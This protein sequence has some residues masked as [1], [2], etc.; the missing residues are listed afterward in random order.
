MRAILLLVLAIAVAAAGGAAYLVNDY[1]QAQRQLAEDAGPALP[2]FTGQRVLVADETIP[3]GTALRSSM[4]RWQPWPPEDIMPAYK[5][6]GDAEGMT[7]R[8]V[9]RQRS[10]HEEVMQGRIV[11]RT[12]AAGEPITDRMVFERVNANFLAGALNPG[13][14]AIALPVN[15]VTGTA[16]FILPGDYVDV[17]LTH[18]LRDT[19][20]RGVDQGGAG[21]PISRY[22]A[23]TIIESLR[24]LAVDRV[25]QDTEAEPKVVQTVTVEASASEVEIL[26]LARQM[27]S[28][29]LTLR[30]LSDRQAPVGLA[31]LLGFGEAAGAPERDIVSDR[32]VS[33]ALDYMM[34][35]SQEE[36]RLRREAELAA[37]RARLL[38]ELDLD[39]EPMP[40]RPASPSTPAQAAPEPQG[41]DWEVTVYHGADGPTVYSDQG[42]GQAWDGDDQSGGDSGPGTGL[43]D[44]GPDGDPLPLTPDMER[45]IPIEE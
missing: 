45:E 24:V 40:P 26:N 7:E 17:V 23:E 29:T 5:V 34:R 6:I 16:G 13:M 39:D 25:F 4:V 10:A 44:I 41:P 27:G 38:A 14:R 35:G 22:V 28:V 20:P 18:D 43:P 42:G 32:S 36:E 8:Q 3:A 15:Q 9:F 11:R 2:T 30:A 31:A 1:L 21:A 33:R 37:E 19:L 12:I